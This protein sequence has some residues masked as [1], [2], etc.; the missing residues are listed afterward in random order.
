MH[1]VGGIT[2]IGPFSEGELLIIL[3]IILIVMGPGRLPQLARALGE[4]MREFRKAMSGEYEEE[5]R[6]GKPREE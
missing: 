2:P 1:R 5:R 6:K 4:A 3:L